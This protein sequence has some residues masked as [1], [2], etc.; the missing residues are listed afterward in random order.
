M[1]STQKWT[2]DLQVEPDA[3]FLVNVI[4][5]PSLLPSL[6]S[7]FYL[8]GA[9]HTDTKSV[10]GLLATIKEQASKWLSMRH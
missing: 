8:N 1:I 7:P 2:L 9:W 10:I 3:R 6:M 4:S 5:L